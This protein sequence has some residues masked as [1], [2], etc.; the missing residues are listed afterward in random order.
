M[1][2]PINNN[3]SRI[4][5]HTHKFNSYISLEYMQVLITRAKANSIIR[6]ELTIQ[7]SLCFEKWRMVS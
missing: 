6:Q 4:T 7:K 1:Y 5:V 2:T 3:K